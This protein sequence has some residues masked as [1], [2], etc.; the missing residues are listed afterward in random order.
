MHHPVFLL[1]EVL[2]LFRLFVG[3]FFYFCVFCSY[4]SKLLGG[5]VIIGCLPGRH[6]WCW[7]C[8]GP[9]YYVGCWCDHSR[10]GNHSQRV[11]DFH[12]S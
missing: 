11:S 9:P 6:S 8:A 4:F 7:Q 3:W 1:L 12:R 5:A 2:L 10:Y